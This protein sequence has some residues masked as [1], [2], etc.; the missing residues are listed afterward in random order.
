[1]FFGDIV[2][3]LSCEVYA[4]SYYSL[5]SLNDIWSIS[6]YSYLISWHLHLEIEQHLIPCFQELL[7]FEEVRISNFQYLNQFCHCNNGWSRF[8]LSSC[9]DISTDRRHLSLIENIPSMEILDGLLSLLQH[10]M[11]SA[12]LSLDCFSFGFKHFLNVEL[13]LLKVLCL[14]NVGFDLT[15]QIDWINI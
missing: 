11:D 4:I 1:M 7:S 3:E 13:W 2:F 12:V 6:F 15:V 5:V 10:L 8:F 14:M 9:F